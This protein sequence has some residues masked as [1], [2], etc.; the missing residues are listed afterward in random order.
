MAEVGDGL[1]ERA[2]VGMA[3]PLDDVGRGRVL[4][5]AAGV[6]D[7]DAVGHARDD[8]EVVRDVDHGHALL[9]AQAVELEQ[10][11]ILREHVEPGRGLVEHGHGRLAHAGHRDRHALLLPTRELMRVAAGEARIA[12]QLDAIER[13]VHGLER[14]LAGA[15]RAQDVEDRVADAQRR[16]E[17]SARIL[18]HVRHDA[19]AQVA[20]RAL[21]APA[22]LLAAD[23]DRPAAPHHS[24]TRVAE[25]RERGRRLAAA[26]L[27]DEAED[28]A[29]RRARS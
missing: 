27:A 1:H 3:R 13:R 19:A 14:A 28:L 6:H 8:R 9:A 12:A 4:D 25:Q 22:H 26:G 11:A 17:R 10:D 16:V 21:V 7:D 5:D 2:R 24:R 15:V 18:R 29:G 20:Q 23:L